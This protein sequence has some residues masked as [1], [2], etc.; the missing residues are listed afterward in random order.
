MSEKTVPRAITAEE[1]GRHAQLV[2]VRDAINDVLEN[3]F[4]GVAADAPD[5]ERGRGGRLDDALRELDWFGHGVTIPLVRDVM[6]AIEECLVEGD[7]K[8][9]EAVKAL[10]AARPYLFYRKG[11]HGGMP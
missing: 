8:F 11:D 5:D 4:G 1:I 10:K 3:G 2:A 6:C 9:R 7:V